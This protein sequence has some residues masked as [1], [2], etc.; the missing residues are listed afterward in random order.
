M[1]E[2]AAV[3]GHDGRRTVALLTELRW[4]QLPT[5][6]KPRVFHSQEYYADNVVGRRQLLLSTKPHLL[7]SPT[8]RTVETKPK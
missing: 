7:T 6:A 8:G 1:A 2:N 3:G 4:K 5:N